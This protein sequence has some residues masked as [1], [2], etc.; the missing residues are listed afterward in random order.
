MSRG[1]APSKVAEWSD[2]LERFASSGQSVTQFC[3]TEDVSQPSFFRSE[4]EHL[5]VPRVRLAKAGANLHL[6]RF[7]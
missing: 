7:N 5:A 4:T 1:S 3:V 2:R 6:R